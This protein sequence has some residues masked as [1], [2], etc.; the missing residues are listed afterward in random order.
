MDEF[1]WLPDW[2]AQGDSTANV[3]KIQFG[4]GYV[5]R[6]TK[7]MNPIVKSW[8]MSFNNRTDAEIA[9]IVEFFE[10]RYGVVA[11]TWTPPDE[12]Q[13]KWVCAR[14]NKTKQGDNVTS[15]SASFDRVYEP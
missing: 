3:S 10:D 8:N 14:W 6:Q 7:G 5:Q 13:A 11:F 9:D 4:D 2:N 15:L 12:D 1:T